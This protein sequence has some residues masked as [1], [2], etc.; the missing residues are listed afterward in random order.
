MG[1]F[2]TSGLLPSFNFFSFF[3]WKGSDSFELNQAK[4]GCPFFPMATGHLRWLR[5]CRDVKS[6]LK[7]PRCVF[8]RCQA[9]TPAWQVLA[10]DHAHSG[11]PSGGCFLVH[12]FQPSFFSKTGSFFFFSSS[13]FFLFSQ[14]FGGFFSNSDPWVQNGV[15]SCAWSPLGFVSSPSCISG[16]RCPTECRVDFFFNG[17]AVFGIPV[18]LHELRPFLQST[19]RSVPRFPKRL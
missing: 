7:Q 2:A 14:G 16:Q 1:C 3:C 6:G 12:A 8:L 18:N 9:P 19:A 15:G 5:T 11:H 10:K 4:T 17:N 13:F